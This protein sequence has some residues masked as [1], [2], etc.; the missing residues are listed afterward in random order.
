MRIS[1]DM[2]EETSERKQERLSEKNVGVLTMAQFIPGSMTNPPQGLAPG[3][4]ASWNASKGG[5]DV[6]ASQQAM[7]QA[8]QSCTGPACGAGGQ[9]QQKQQ[10]IPLQYD[11][12]AQELAQAQAAHPGTVDPNSPLVRLTKDLVV[13]QD[14]FFALYTPSDAARYNIAK[15]YFIGRGI[16]IGGGTTAAPGTTGT[17]HLS[18]T[19]QAVP[20]IG[21]N[22][23]AASPNYYAGS[24]EYS[25][26]AGSP[27]QGFP[28]QDLSI[29]RAEMPFQPTDLRVVPG[30]GQGGM[31]SYAIPTASLAVNNPWDP[32]L[33]NIEASKRANELTNAIVTGRAGYNIGEGLTPQAAAARV[34]QLEAAKKAAEASGN[35][36]LAWDL[37]NRESQAAQNLVEFGSAYHH[38][39]QQLGIPVRAN[40]YEMGADV[41]TEYLKGTPTRSAEAFSP[42]S[43]LLTGVL[44]TYN[45]PLH[46]KAGLGLQQ[47]IWNQAINREQGKPV[48]FADF[49][50]AAA[51]LREI[52]ESGAQGP[53]GYLYGGQNYAGR[54]TSRPLGEQVTGPQVHIT[55]TAP[56]SDYNANTTATEGRLVGGKTV[57][58]TPTILPQEPQGLSFIPMGKFSTEREVSTVYRPSDITMGIVNAAAGTPIAPV[59]RDIS[60]FYF[61]GQDITTV[62][63]TSSRIVNASELPK[64]GGPDY[65]PMFV[66]P[67]TGE[68]SPKLVEVSRKETPK[69][70]ETTVTT[71]D[72]SKVRLT[73]TEII[74]QTAAER[75]SGDTYVSQA[76]GLNKISEKITPELIQAN[77][78]ALVLSN[79]VLSLGSITP[80]YKD[81]QNAFVAGAIRGPMEKPVTTG[82][83]VGV[84]VAFGGAFRI[85][86]EIT[87]YAASKLGGTHPLA[88]M[89]ITNAPKYLG[90]GLGAVYGADVGIR[91]TKGGT[92][93]SPKAAGRVGS[94]TTTEII[95]MGI[96][97]GIGYRAPEIAT[98]AYNRIS[99]IDVGK[100]YEGVLSKTFSARQ[101]MA[102]IENIGVGGGKQ[103]P[104]LEYSQPITNV[105][106]PSP[107]GPAQPFS[108]Q[109]YIQPK[110]T[111]RSFGPAYDI[112]ERNMVLTYGTTEPR[113]VENV[114]R[115][116]SY[117]NQMENAIRRQN[118]G[119]DI[120]EAAMRLGAASPGRKPIGESLFIQRVVSPSES[121]FFSRSIPYTRAEPFMQPQMEPATSTVGSRPYAPAPERAT[122]SIPTVSERTI[123]MELANMNPAFREQIQTMPGK[124]G[125]PLTEIER[126]GFLPAVQRDMR[127]VPQTSSRSATETRQKESMVIGFPATVST[128]ELSGTGISK[129]KTPFMVGFVKPT[130]ETPGAFIGEK[131][132]VGPSVSQTMRPRPETRTMRE[133]RPYPEPQPFTD[134]TPQKIGFPGTV[135]PPLPFP[136]FPSIPG[137]AG[138]GGSRK[139]RS[140]FLEVFNMGL[141]IG[142]IMGSPAR[143]IRA[144]SWKSPKHPTKR[145]QT[146]KR[147]R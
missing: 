125:Y 60:D 53:Y 82:V 24:T 112:A 35:Y 28:G 2:Y 136:G 9:P 89:A 6:Y 113:F 7:I 30:M 123:N 26:I 120:G 59:L 63:G 17:V 72:Y 43:G 18:E 11:P 140:A 78:P 84:G 46:N 64:V 22:E 132:F 110:D 109:E 138:G 121:G 97:A 124:R 42:V 80:G 126:Q 118:I 70:I 142:G 20:N 68:L 44:P 81:F 54:E 119:V 62:K 50:P 98:G 86:E 107:S 85:G 41:A 14:Y 8:Q 133:P 135:T 3:S 103:A 146:K 23:R 15:E 56:I 4:Y 16:Q 128:G 77:G 21:R 101:R 114:V 104:Y 5:W 115:S 134:I 33:I 93:L 102:G 71:T 127:N 94:I 29:P 65:T 83:S 106:K 129:R 74:A 100:A 87:G 55:T 90:Y 131:G 108:L 144:K 10:E 32:T 96:G 99:S 95:P 111:G 137:A 67:M 143:M 58:A 75:M 116:Q 52:V 91:A 1:W 73:G 38:I 39:G 79:P 51:K 25:L 92:E 88:A 122:F 37:A 117:T 57:A 13:P 76:L 48:S 36:R 66:N 61:P 105:P 19:G 139:R 31:P 147:R 34:Q 69:G 49:G 45:P 141:D 47:D 145:T 40:P 27:A 130:P 12:T